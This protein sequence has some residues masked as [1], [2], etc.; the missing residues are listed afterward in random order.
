[1]RT[2]P[3]NVNMV[4]YGKINTRLSP[5][6]DHYCIDIVVPSSD[7]YCNWKHRKL[8]GEK[9]SHKKV[10]EAWPRGYATT[11]S[12]GVGTTLGCFADVWH[13]PEREVLT[14][15]DV[16][17]KCTCLNRSL[18]GRLQTKCASSL[19]SLRIWKPLAVRGIMR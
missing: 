12:L 4:A 2:A 9:N 19:S 6:S 5:A 8:I 10:G 1:M 11:G 17:C 16:R 3:G 14:E 7:H 13:R 15:D 18:S